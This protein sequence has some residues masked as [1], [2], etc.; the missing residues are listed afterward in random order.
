MFETNSYTGST[1]LTPAPLLQIA[2][3]FRA[4]RLLTVCVDM[5]L[6]TWLSDGRGVTPTEVGIQY[7][8]AERP[9]KMLLAACA[10]LNLLT[11]KSGKY[12]NSMLAQRFLVKGEEFY[13]GDF[14]TFLDKR[15]YANWGKLEEALRSNNTVAWGPENGETIFDPANE[16][17]ANLFWNAMF[18]MSEY[19]AHALALSHD[20]TKYRNLLDVGGAPG[21]FCFELCRFF[22]QLEATVFDLPFAC[23]I[24]ATKIEE[25]GCQDRVGVHAGD[26]R[27][28]EA[29]PSGSDLI[30]LSNIL[31]DW[32]DQTGQE[33]LKKTFD[34]VTDGGSVFIVEAFI[35]NDMTGP[36]AATLMSLNMLV[37]TLGENRTVAEYSTWLSEAGFC[38]IELVRFRTDAAGAN[39]ALVGHKR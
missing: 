11:K 38:D 34:A 12:Y 17:M 13:F 14:I 5:E 6:F 3:G 33:L 1:P 32:D 27:S 19:T 23:D 30:L 31:H 9:S 21:A 8:L 36:M 20:F 15:E 7:S 37:E 2:D 35:N 25:K 24:T 29:L 28:S 10:A 16:V 26:F 4:S 18:S 22:P 39:G